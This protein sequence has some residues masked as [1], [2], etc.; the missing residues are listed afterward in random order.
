MQPRVPILKNYIGGEWIDSTTGEL[1]EI[2]NPAT[3]ELISLYPLSTLEEVDM[4]VAAA[5]KAFGG[6]R[7]T[8]IPKRVQL[9]FKLR[10]K[11][12]EARKDLAR[13]IS[14]EHGKT[15]AEGLQEI[16]RCLQYVEDAC[17]V[18][19]TMR[20]DFTEDIARGVDEYY[21]RE[22]LGVF[23]VLPPFNFPAMISAYFVWA[24]ACG[25]TVVVKPSKYCPNT[26]I[27][28]A[29]IVE[30]CGFPR[31]VVNVVNG[32]GSVA[33]NRLITH[34]DV[35]GVTFVGSSGAGR[36]IYEAACA[37]GKRAQ[38]QGGAKNHLVV[39]ED[40]RLDE[41]VLRNII[42]SCFGH[43]GE[44]CFAGSNILIAESIYDE[45]KEKFIKAAQEL[46]LGNGLDEGVTLGPVVDR[47]HLDQLLRE[48]ESGVNE[49]AKLILDGRGVKV[50]GYPNGCFLGPTVFEAEPGM[51][52][53]TEEVFGPV[54]CLK[55]IKDL[56]EAIKIIDQNPFGHTAVIYT[57][58]GKYAREF[59]RRTNVGQVG[60]NIGTPAPIAFY[61]VGG[62]KISGFGSTRGRASD[63][64]DFYTDKKVVVSQWLKPINLGDDESFVW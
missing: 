10:Y 49:G 5:K 14:L 38:C 28:M 33:G 53:F 44:R 20:G 19:E 12:E 61:P 29:R 31:G 6:W 27:E 9:M 41:G 56:K 40:A 30:E 8:P 2:R 58:T 60:V 15:F 4:A 57:E 42:N 63:A 52:I 39:M 47:E 24:I 51:R 50:E 16:E 59:I 26:M 36:K 46:K 11:L 1:L 7:S 62:R 21:I 13:T 32:S 48:I 18:P 22:P 55:K 3:D 43:V 34:P 17:A 37:H 64:V 45:F 54:R 35:A 25:N 23:V